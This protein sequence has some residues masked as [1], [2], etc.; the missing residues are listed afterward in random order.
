[1]NDREFLIWMH[2]RLTEVHGES[3]LVDYMHKFRAIISTIPIFQNT[4]NDGRGC[5]GI[6][7]LKEKLF[8]K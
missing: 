3:P 8:I 5:N 4:P 1:M 6:D 7:E 2:E